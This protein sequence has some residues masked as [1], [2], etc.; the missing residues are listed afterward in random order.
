MSDEGL[1]PSATPREY[2]KGDNF[3]MLKFKCMSNCQ[4]KQVHGL[5][6]E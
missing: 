2:E 3:F 1:K 6:K 5:I 4:S